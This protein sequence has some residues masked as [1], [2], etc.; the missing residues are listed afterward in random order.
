M[1]NTTIQNKL[2]LIGLYLLAF[3]GMFILGYCSHKPDTV[4]VTVKEKVTIL[5]HDTV[6]ITY[7][8]IVIKGKGTIKYDTTVKFVCNPFTAQLDTVANN[9]RDTARI[10]YSYPQNIFQAYFAH[11][12]TVV[13][14]DHTVELYLDKIVYQELKRPWWE[15]PAWT[16]GG[17]IAGAIIAGTIVYIKEGNK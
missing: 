7:P 4:K 13:Y 2:K 1:S 11:K 16:T 15:V 10:T 17:F 6:R 5:V 9:G 8:P 3:L 14:R 12:D